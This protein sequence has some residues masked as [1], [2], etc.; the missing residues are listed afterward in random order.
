M[1]HLTSSK[2]IARADGKAAPP[3]PRVKLFAIRETI[4]SVPVGRAV[5][6]QT[7]NQSR[8]DE[9]PLVAFADQVLG[10]AAL[11]SS[12]AQ[13]VS[14]VRAL[15]KTLSFRKSVEAFLPPFINSPP[16]VFADTDSGRDDCP[17]SQKRC[18]SMVSP[19]GLL[20][21]AGEVFL[22]AARFGSGR[23]VSATE[24]RPLNGSCYFRLPEEAVGDRTRLTPPW[25]CVGVVPRLLNTP[26][27]A[28]VSR[29]AF[30]HPNA[31]ATR[32]SVSSE[33]PWAERSADSRRVSPRPA[34]PRRCHPQPHA[35]R[36][37]PWR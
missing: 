29:S 6:K 20:E 27:G 19:R 23:G 11:A 5:R 35:T 36:P 8:K 13:H 26:P 31:T 28:T 1:F 30:A 22:G 7:E 14:S 12:S 21:W 4:F 16:G 37:A 3:V 34:N 10:Q 17:T 18:E 32:P 24:P 25:R 2:R 15:V 33:S 9:D